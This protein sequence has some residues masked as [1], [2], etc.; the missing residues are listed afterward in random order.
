M[1]DVT[2]ALAVTQDDALEAPQQA[3]LDTGYQI[4]GTAT[5]A[6][7]VVATMKL[8]DGLYIVDLNTTL[9]TP[10]QVQA[11]LEALVLRLRQGGVVWNTNLP[12]TPAFT[13]LPT[14]TWT[15]A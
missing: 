4:V 13:D 1:A 8:D 5:A 7:G 2:Y 15:P 14:G 10:A 11:L 12:G 6:Q 3:A 9:K